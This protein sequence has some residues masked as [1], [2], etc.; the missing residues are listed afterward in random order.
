MQAQDYI[1]L[2]L[3]RLKSSEE[4]SM[5]RDEFYFVILKE[6]TG[7]CS[8]SHAGQRLAPGDVLLLK[9]GTGGKLCASHGAELVF[10]FFTLRLEQLIPLFDGKEISLL[11]SITTGL[12]SPKLFRASAALAKE[13]RR[14]IIGVPA[15]FNLDHR[16]Q[17]LRIAGTLLSEEFKTAH[18]QRMSSVS[19][20]KHLAGSFENLKVDELLNLSVGELA[21]KFGY[22]RRHLNRL[23]HQFFGYS[24][25]ALRME[26]RLLRAVCLLRDLDAK[27]VTVAE[28]CGFNH[29]GLFNNCFKRRFGESP[30]GWRKQFISH[31]EIQPA[32]PRG[33]DSKCPLY[34]KG[35][36]PM[37]A[38]PNNSV[39]RLFKK[40]H[41]NFETPA[42]A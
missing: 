9:G 14:L 2:R 6:G 13:C 40:Y 30:G 41:R 27:V 37:P 38:W 33:D 8:G 12:N 35:Q 19:V 21:E 20:D 39:S 7:N 25:A 26:M 32:V 1:T 34:S 23:F 36:C 16:S 42:H 24:V 11:Q 17:L 18:R 22:T 5:D 4:Y 3:V 31:Q 15:Q 10:W 29:L 28:Q